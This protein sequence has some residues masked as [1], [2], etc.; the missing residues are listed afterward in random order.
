MRLPWDA[1]LVRPG[2]EH[3]VGSFLFIEE[4][5]HEPSTSTSTDPRGRRR[6]ALEPLE[7][8]RLLASSLDFGGFIGDSSPSF[9]VSPTDSSTTS[10][11]FSGDSFSGDSFA[12]DVFAPDFGFGDGLGSLVGNFGGDWGSN[13]PDSGTGMPFPVVTPQ[14]T[15]TVPS[16]GSSLS[17]SPT[18][19]VLTFS[20]PIGISFVS[21][22]D[23]RLE[24]IDDD[25]N[26]TTVSDPGFDSVAVDASQTQLTVN[27]SR[28]LPT[29]RYRLVVVGGGFLS[30]QLAS[31]TWDAWQD[32]IVSEFTV[33][34][35]GATLFD[36]ED[37]GTIGS[38]QVDQPGSLDASSGLADVSLYKITLEPGHVWRLGVEVSAFAQ[39][40]GLM[41]SLTLFD[42]QGNVIA[43]RDAGSGL[44]T[45][46]VDPYL[47]EGLA[48]GVYYIG[49][50][51]AGNLPGSVGGYDPQTGTLGTVDFSQ[52]SGAFTLKVVADPIDKPTTVVNWSLV[53]A[54]S[55]GTAPTGVVLS[56]SQPIDPLSL[57]GQ[58]GADYV[59]RLVDTTGR[60]WNVSPS[61]YQPQ[62]NLLSLTFD[63]PL[64]PGSYRLEVNPNGGLTDL[65]GQTPSA[66]GQ[67]TGVLATFT[68]NAASR[69]LPSSAIN[70]LGVA[71]PTQGVGVDQTTR[72]TARAATTY[73]VVVLAPGFYTLQLQVVRGVLQSQRIGSDGLVSVADADQLGQN[74]HLMYLSPGVYTFQFIGGPSGATSFSWSL[75]SLDI[76]WE[77][78]LDNGLGQSTAIS[79][80]YSSP[81]SG[82][83]PGSTPPL[84]STAAPLPNA[85]SIGSLGGAGSNPGGLVLPTLARTAPWRRADCSWPCRRTFSAVLNRADSLRLRS[86]PR[87]PSPLCQAAGL[88]SSRA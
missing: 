59:L 37:L 26:V 64:P 41:P 24:R 66:A 87:R 82:G 57:R 47:F 9:D 19:L 43:V 32:N 65:L 36:A 86:G 77:S 44:P 14:L 18:S 33:E 51:S 73:R 48:P 62:G 8:R 17:S 69:S 56:F 7:S 42:A 70:N 88:P 84:F 35:S 78:L 21:S 4:C 46:P 34:H 11:S 31:S 61:G 40:S 80:R 76:S 60:V 29:G 10:T 63:Q 75:R 52:A 39:G 38:T 20:E 85:F 49:I 12:T 28:S 22:S 3:P 54:D 45:N 1:L 50:S 74:N 5:R 67:P 30:S 79:L 16:D 71:W 15:S 23:L 13:D 72:I 68:I 83:L 25:G 2:F 53:W 58:F 55:R 81:L 27:L 6:I